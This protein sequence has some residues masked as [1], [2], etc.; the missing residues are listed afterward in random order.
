MFRF[1]NILALFVMEQSLVN[2][3]VF[4]LKKNILLRLSR[5]WIVIVAHP[6]AWFI[7]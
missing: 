7:V 4:F 1:S 6:L 2:G 5:E 3:L